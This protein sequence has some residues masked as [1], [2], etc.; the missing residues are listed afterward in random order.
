MATSTD[1]SRLFMGR[2]SYF[3]AKC[4]GMLAIS[5]PSMS[6]SL[7]WET[8]GS[9]S[10]FPRAFRRSLSLMWPSLINTS[11]RGDPFSC[12]TSRA[13]SSCSRLIR[14]WFRSISPKSWCLRDTLLKSWDES[15]GVSSM[16]EG[17]GS[18]DSSTDAGRIW[19][20]L[21]GSP[22]EAPDEGVSPS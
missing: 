1:S 7:R 18:G 6:T 22:G 2:I 13:S 15:T 3:L 5:S 14:A 8:K 19:S 20:A 10:C 4:M 16:G 9:P 21:S 17:G 12:W 11:P